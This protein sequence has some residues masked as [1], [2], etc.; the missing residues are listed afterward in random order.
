M[1]L[2]DVLWVK[3]QHRRRG[4][5]L[6][7]PP[8]KFST[9]TGESALVY[10]CHLH[11]PKPREITNRISFDCLSCGCR[12]AAAAGV[13]WSMALSPL[14]PLFILLV[15]SKK[16]KPASGRRWCH[17]QGCLFVC[18]LTPLKRRFGQLGAL[19]ALE[20]SGSQG[21]TGLNKLSHRHGQFKKRLDPLREAY[22]H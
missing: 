4:N 3:R 16:S 8:L 15:F 5:P 9:L 14:L 2:Y 1:I 18:K 6:W 12:D 7:F 20:T 10:A 17:R 11:P 22:H 21:Q 19:F 13:I